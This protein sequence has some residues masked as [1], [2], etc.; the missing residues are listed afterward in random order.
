MGRK[1]YGLTNYI[2]CII[3]EMSRMKVVVC[4]FTQISFC[5]RDQVGIK[6]KHIKMHY[7]PSSVIIKCIFETH[8]KN[9]GKKDRIKSPI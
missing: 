4:K 6:I 3:S 2:L 7:E 1:R 8:L 9:T 5:E